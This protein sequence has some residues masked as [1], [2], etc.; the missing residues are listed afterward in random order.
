MGRWMGTLLE[1]KGRGR[2]CRVLEGRPSRGS[3]F[4]KTTTTTT[5]TTNNNEIN[6]ASVYLS[7]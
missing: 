7:L 5:T 1:A 6:A 4:D 3:T 2:G